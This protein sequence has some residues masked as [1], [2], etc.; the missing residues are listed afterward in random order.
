MGILYWANVIPLF[1]IIYANEIIIKIY[2]N[3]AINAEKSII[4]SACGACNIK[5]CTGVIISVL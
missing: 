1:V 3:G 4:K 2:T 5:L